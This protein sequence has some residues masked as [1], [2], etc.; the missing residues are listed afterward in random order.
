M[1]QEADSLVLDLQYFPSIN[2]F[3]DSIRL[4]Q[5]CFYPD[6]PFRKSGFQNRLLIPASGKVISLSIPLA[7]GRSVRSPY[8]SVEIDHLQH[9]QR[10]HFRSIDSVFGS[11]PFYFQYKDE[12]H[13]LFQTKEKYLYSWNLLCLD[14]VIEK[15]K[16]NLSVIEK[17]SNESTINC[18]TIIQDKYKPS[19][20]NA[21]ENGPFVK[22]Q[23]VFE[24][25]IG[26][27]ANMSI[28][29]LL[30]NMGPK[31]TLSFLFT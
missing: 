14:W 21:K 5:F 20:Y 7:G 18:L 13:S 19:N 15:L 3:K 22:Y 8:K 1:L 23:Q 26:F 2:W 30:F 16:L 28:L 29:D 9:W 27:C 12:I 17:S 4:N 11:T 24:D 10:D 25:R 6:A 31:K